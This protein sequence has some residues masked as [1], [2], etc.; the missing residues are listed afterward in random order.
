[1]SA[2]AKPL[3]FPL[4]LLVL[5]GVGAALLGLG[6]AEHFGAIDLLSRWLP[7]PDADLAAIGAGGA[8]M[9]IA[10]FGIIRSLRERAV[11]KGPV[12]R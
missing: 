3:P 11:R 2:P 10:A 8:M 7:V 1:M 4:S 9:A 6:L 12:V 5:D